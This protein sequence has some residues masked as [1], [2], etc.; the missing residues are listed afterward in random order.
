MLNKSDPVLKYAAIS[1]CRNKKM[2][3]DYVENTRPSQTKL[4]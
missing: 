1:F 3:D 2:N 4:K